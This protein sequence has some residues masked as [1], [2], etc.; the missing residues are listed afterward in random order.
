MVVMILYGAKFVVMT[1]HGGKLRTSWQAADQ[2]GCGIYSLAIFTYGLVIDCSIA[3]VPSSLD[4]MVLASQ[5]ATGH[6]HA[7]EL[8]ITP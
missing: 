5:N 8:L 7:V 4:H 3:S 2:D 6:V 1:I